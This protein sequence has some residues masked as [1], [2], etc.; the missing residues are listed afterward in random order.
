MSCRAK[1]KGNAPLDSMLTLGGEIKF[2]D[3]K[4]GIFQFLK[5]IKLNSRI[6]EQ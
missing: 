6:V 4:N 5:I 2:I 3:I 1:A